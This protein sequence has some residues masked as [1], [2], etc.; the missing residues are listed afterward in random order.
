V[1]ALNLAWTI[2]QV[3]ETI[4]GSAI[5]IA[6]LPTLA[7]FIDR[8]QSDSF[9]QTVNRALR[10]M[11]ALSLPA[12]ALLA[13]VIRPLV[14]VFF[15]YETSQLN[16]VT[17]CT[18][19]FLLSLLGDAWLETA[20]R[21]FYA[22]QNTRTPLVAAFIQVVSFILLAWLISTW[23]GLPGIPVA[24]ATTFTTQAV[25]LLSLQNRKF[26]GLF[27]MEGTLVRAVLAAVVGGLV[28][29]AVL[30]FLPL[31]PIFAALIAL[32]FGAVAVLPF[33]WKETRLLLHL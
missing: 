31:S 29:Y 1:G 25:V 30:R 14:A 11:L 27:N 20:V 7:E 12:A 16:L 22:N 6:L 13:V 33:I 5:A 2:Q 17:W 3:P 32:G 21:S 28:A 23:I 10:V 24:A 26:P 9:R 4:I 8:A 18:W 19:A 15:G